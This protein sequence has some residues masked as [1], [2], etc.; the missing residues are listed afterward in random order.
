M[1]FIQGEEFVMP[2]APRPRGIIQGT[3][4]GVEQWRRQA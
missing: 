3:A 1:S 2:P 4:W